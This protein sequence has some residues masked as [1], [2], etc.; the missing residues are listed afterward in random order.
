MTPLCTLTDLPVTQC[1]CTQHHRAEATVVSIGALERLAGRPLPEYRARLRP[2]WR[3]P[4]PEPT[5]C[6]HRRGDLCADCDRLLDGLL[7]DLP[8]LVE[9]LG[10]AMR[11]DCRFAPHGHR[12]GDVETPDE[13]PIPWNPAA[14][15][16][17]GEL[18]QFMVDTRNDRGMCRRRLLARLSGLAQHAH[19]VIDRPKDREY[20]M[21]PQCRAEIL[22]EDRTLV[23]CP[24][25]HR[26]ATWQQHQQDLLDASGDVMLT[27]NQ[28]VGVLCSGGE[29]ITRRR[30]YYLVEHHGLP[31]EEIKIPSWRKG[32][33]ITDDQWVYRLRDVRDLQA[34]LAG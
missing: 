21:C 9:E 27:T 11:K 4:Q 10:F 16:V 13:A 8:H 20:T 34:R 3:V 7:A 1:A 5:I 25:C 19:R 14:A 30:V 12:R 22:V 32:R 26:S 28:L 18:H 6:E 24:D 15:R 23:T 17:L 2:P 33:I 29:L 31:R